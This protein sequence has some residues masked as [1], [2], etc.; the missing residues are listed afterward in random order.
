[1]RS[2]LFS[3]LGDIEVPLS[4]ILAVLTTGIIIYIMY[5]ESAPKDTEFMGIFSTLFF[6][7]M[8]MNIIN[9]I[10]FKILQ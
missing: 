5:G 2:K 7:N 8:Y 3:V 6:L 1:M 10:R 9:F 4:L